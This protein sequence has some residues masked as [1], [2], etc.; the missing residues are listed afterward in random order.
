MKSKTS[1]FNL[2]IFRKN[3][4]HYWPL[5]ALYLSYLVVVIPLNLYLNITNEYYGTYQASRQ[6]MAMENTLKTGFLPFP[7]FLFAVVMAAAVFS[8]L[9]SAR[10]ANMIHALPVNRVELFVTNYLSGISFMLIPQLLIF[11]VS[12]LVCVATGITCMQYLLLW[13][14]YKA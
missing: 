14:V 13:L 10:N 12:V 1:C 5:W 4:T 11:V 7:V 8:Y 9:Y 6:Y 2:T 3:F